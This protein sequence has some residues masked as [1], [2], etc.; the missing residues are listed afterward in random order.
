MSR[1]HCSRCGQAGHNRRNRNCPLN[2]AQN[3]RPTL[4]PSTPPGPPPPFTRSST[5]PGPPPVMPRRAPRNTTPGMRTINLLSAAMRV[6]EILEQFI[7]RQDDS[8]RSE[9]ILTVVAISITFCE[10]M[11]LAL[12]SD[13][14][15]T[16]LITPI[17][18]F[19]RFSENI[20]IFNAIMAGGSYAINASFQNNRFRSAVTSPPNPNASVVKR[21]S[22]YFKEV[23]LVQDLTITEDAPKC[24]CPL[25]FDDF[26][27]T[28][29]IVTN[30]NHSFCGTCVKGFSTSIKDKTKIPNCPMCR[31]NLTEFKVGSQQVYADIQSH[32]LNL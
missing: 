8:P 1:I 22:A 23:S 10:K 20:G 24:E 18:I 9:Y 12:E 26:A 17:P 16:P 30:C 6:L 4:P 19:D 27:A 29:I 14:V 7:P 15:E 32:I 11:N 2:T 31:T 3:L 25:C 28:D 5:P 13:S 21:T